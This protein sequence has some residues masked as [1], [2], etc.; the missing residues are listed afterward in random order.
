MFRNMFYG[1]YSFVANTLLDN[2]I[3]EVHLMKEIH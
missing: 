2:S 3:T 1:I